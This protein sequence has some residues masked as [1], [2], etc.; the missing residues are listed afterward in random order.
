MTK[1]WRDEAFVRLVKRQCGRITWAQLKALDVPD[2]TIG[3]WIRAGYLARVLPK[4]YA[5]GHTA[6]S[7]EADLWAAV[8]Y[9]GPGAMLSHASAAHHRSL[10]I[11]PPK[12][13]HVSTP[14]EKIRS[15]PGRIKVHAERDLTRSRRQGIPT[16][17][18]E[19]TV[20]DLAATEDIKLVRR[21]LSVLDY[22]KELDVRALEAIGGKGRP[23]T[24]ALKVALKKH[25]PELAHTNGKL[26]EAFLYLCERYD[27]PIPRFN[28]WVHDEEVDA[29]WPEHGLVVEVDGLDNHSSTAQIRMNRRKDLKLRAHGLR[30]VRYDW[31]LVTRAPA[32]VHADLL[33]HLAAAS[34]TRRQQSGQRGIGN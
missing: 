30:V 14:R 33:R 27:L 16:T 23:G 28:E 25:Q 18:N 29:H 6:P 24:R 32:E 19:Q 12:V 3:T 2:G 7:R 22:R 31:D 11:H 10:I 34:V 9:A 4:V 17:T 26:E 1:L 8:L 5:V 20:L 15:I 21:A 13:I